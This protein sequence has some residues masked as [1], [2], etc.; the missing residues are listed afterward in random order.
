ME[1]TLPHEDE[2]AVL[3]LYSHVFLAADLMLKNYKKLTDHWKKAGRLSKNREIEM[4]IYFATWLGYL[5][6]TGEG[7]QKLGMRK[8]L[9]TG[10]PQEFSEVIEHSNRVGKI[11]KMHHDALRHFRNDVF[12]LRESPDKLMAF[13]KSKPD[14][15]K[16]AEE[17]H[18]SF[19]DFFSCY[20]ISFAVHC[21]LNGRT[22]EF[23]G[24][25]G[26][27]R[28]KRSRSPAQQAGSV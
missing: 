19:E 20:R 27:G 24:M 17:L 10:R 22:D 23:R 8:L 16:W 11:L 15:V 21:A 4:R 6:A 13:F 25:F 3:T 18:A 2:D 1:A 9:E 12:H 5:A 28:P 14:R 26:S 7:F